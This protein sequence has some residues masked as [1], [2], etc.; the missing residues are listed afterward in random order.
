MAIL[1]RGAAP[2]SG[3]DSFEEMD[4]ALLAGFVVPGTELPFGQRKIAAGRLRARVAAVQFWVVEGSQLSHQELAN[5]IG[6]SDRFLSYQFPKQSEMYAFPPPELA[7]SLVGASA[8]SRVWSEIATLIR[9]VFIALET[10]KAG[11][12]LMAGLVM[13]HRTN[14]ALGDTDAYFAMAMRASIRDY[15]HRRTLSIANLFTDGVRMA[16]EDWVDADE[17]SLEFVADRVGRFL[18]GPVQDASKPYS[19]NRW[20]ATT[21]SRP[22]EHNRRELRKPQMLVFST[23]SFIV[24]VPQLPVAD[25]RNIFEVQ[26]E[27]RNLYES[28]TITQNLSQA[29]GCDW[30]TGRFVP[31]N[32][33]LK[34]EW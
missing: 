12:S 30:G 6:M 29:R 20:L 28:S 31:D 17:P 8:S 4:R 9:P 14:P 10:N 32:F 21:A 7:R 5:R 27:R 24:K 33:G 26:Q 1:P 3:P 13:I 2:V 19:P 16:F 34:S 25:A 22:F 18:V 15:R 11:C 23:D